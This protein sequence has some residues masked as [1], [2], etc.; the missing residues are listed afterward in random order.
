MLKTP[1]DEI[2]NGRFISAKISILVKR[3]HKAADYYWRLRR[4]LFFHNEGFFGI[5]SERLL[6]DYA[7]LS[8]QGWEPAYVYQMLS[9]GQFVILLRIMIWMKD[10]LEKN[11]TNFKLLSRF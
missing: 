6:S 3:V 10:F 5:K 11:A 4:I 1:S 8:V 9:Y 7:Y 2:L